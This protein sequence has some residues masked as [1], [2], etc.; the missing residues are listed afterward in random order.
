MRSLDMQP[1]SIKGSPVYKLCIK[2][3][4]MFEKNLYWIPWNGKKIKLWDDSILGNPPL[5]SCSEVDN[6]KLWILAKG[7]TTLWDISSWDDLL[8]IGWEL[9]DPPPEITK[10]A[11]TLTSL[12][13]GKAPIKKNRRDRRGWG[14]LSGSYSTSEGY[15]ISQAIPSVAPN[16]VV[17]KYLW[18]NP[19]IPKIDFF[20]WTLSHKSVFSGE[21][22]KK[23]GMEGPTRCPLYK[24]EEETADHIF[25]GY[26]FSKNVWTEALRLNPG[27]KLPESIQDLLSDWMNLSLFQMAKKELLQTS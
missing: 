10:E 22:L 7:V 23:R 2:A 11:E 18:S 4:D 26:Q 27:I 13:Q 16:P 17:W 25:L 3:L 20:C 1:P 8:W 15:K 6:I 19:F 21:N 14:N 9:G 5:G 12:L 24:S